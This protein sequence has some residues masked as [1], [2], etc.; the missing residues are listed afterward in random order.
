MSNRA[1][2]PAVARVL[3]TAVDM[4]F[5]SRSERTEYQSSLDYHAVHERRRTYCT[6]DRASSHRRRASPVRAWAVYLTCAAAVCHNALKNAAATLSGRDRVPRQLASALPTS[7]SLHQRRGKLSAQRVH[8]IVQEHGRPHFLKHALLAMTSAFHPGGARAMGLSM[9][10]PAC[11]PG[12]ARP[13]CAEPA[14]PRLTASCLRPETHP[15]SLASSAD[16]R[17]PRR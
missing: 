6:H 16:R 3:A 7:R 17:R 15:P 2:S 1:T 14:M 9:I 4:V 10:T 5:D 8:T 13:G 11:I 12:R